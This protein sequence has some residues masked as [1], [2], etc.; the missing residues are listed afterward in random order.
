MR[1]GTYTYIDTVQWCFCQ[2]LIINCLTHIHA[3]NYRQCHW[4]Y[5]SITIQSHLHIHQCSCFRIVGNTQSKVLLIFLERC[6]IY[7]KPFRSTS[8][9][10]RTCGPVKWSCI[11][12]WRYIA[13]AY[14]SC[15]ILV[16]DKADIHPLAVHGLEHVPLYK[17]HNALMSINLQV[18][19]HNTL[20]RASK[21]NFDCQVSSK[22]SIV[23]H[24]ELG[25]KVTLCD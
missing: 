18:L 12:T 14:G 24:M 16:G 6:D 15:Q 1:I 2:Q 5:C 8:S 17:L 3:T 13:H 10:I 9:K 19:S 11:C 20:N 25:I 22:A 7:H 23:G 4:Q 21:C